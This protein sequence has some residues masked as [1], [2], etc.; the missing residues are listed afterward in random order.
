MYKKLDFIVTPLQAYSEK[1][2]LSALAK[3]LKISEN[4][5]SEY[6][7]LRKSIDA[8]SREIKINLG[9]EV[10]I[11]EKL[12]KAEIH[13]P[14]QNNVVN[15]KQVIVVGSGPAG[16]FAAL[17]LIEHGIKPVIIERGKDVHQRK[18]D[19]AAINRQ[20]IIPEDSNYCFGEGGAGTFS[21]GKLY[22]RSKKRGDLQKILSFLNYFG[23]SESILYE[24]HPHIG[25]D[26]LPGIIEKIREF[27]IQSGGEVHF[28]TRVSDLIISDNKIKG[29][30]SSNGDKIFGEAVVLATGHSAK[31]IYFILE[32]NNISLEFKPFALGVRVE[33]PQELID[34]IQYNGNPDYLPAASYSLVSRAGDRGVYSFCMCPG[35]YIVPSASS[36]GETVVNGMSPAAR[37]SPFANSGI[38]VEIRE[39]DLKKYSS[40]NAL[41]GLKFQEEMEKICF[42][43]G[44]LGQVA[45]AQRLSD[46]VKKRLSSDLPPV[47]YIP[48]VISSPMHFWMPDDLVDCMIEGFKTFD[49]KMR[50]FITRE[51]VVVGVESRTSS[52]VRIPRERESMQHPQISGLFPCGEGAGYAGGIVSSA[53]DGENAADAVAAFL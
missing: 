18:R 9:V 16:L 17:R 8:R 11:K 22:T 41:A 6:R 52:P 15:A 20:H 25:S 10:G 32:K 26:K 53:I 12:P 44:G 23:A 31:D 1:E 51:A 43:N 24:A 2:L 21:D 30:I 42:N 47:S 14:L 38:V 39:Q 36:P 46:F 19:I 28:S 48:G 7:I 13:T 50:G 34:N 3:N 40:H 5:I 37:N 45:P 49:N 33:H 29:I 27:I 35:G 4:E